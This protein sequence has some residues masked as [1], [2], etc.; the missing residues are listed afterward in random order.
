MWASLISQLSKESTCAEDPGSIP[1]QK[2]SVREGTGYS[3]TY[4]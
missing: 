4:Q 3:I 2:K 1:G